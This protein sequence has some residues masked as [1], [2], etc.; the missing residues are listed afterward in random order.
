MAI[1]AQKLSDAADAII[2][3]LT[4]YPMAEP[5]IRL[6]TLQE[7]MLYTQGKIVVCGR[8]RPI[9][10]KRLAPGVYRVWLGG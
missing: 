7:I 3:Q 1:V 9:E 10:S 6:G 5:A 2:G 4:S 8:L